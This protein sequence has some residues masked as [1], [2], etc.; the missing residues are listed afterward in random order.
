MKISKETF[1]RV[2]EF[3]QKFPHY[4]IGSNADLPIV[5]GSILSHDH[6]QSGNYAFAMDNAPIENRFKVK[7][8]E[9]IEA[10]I[11]KWPMSVI[12]LK[13]DDR[14]KVSELADYIFNKWKLY[15]DIE[16]EIAAFTDGV[17]HNTITPIARRTG[18]QY[19]LDLA[20][21]NNRTSSEHPDG[22]YH[23]HQNLH[24]I[25]KENIGLIEVMG[26]AVLPA[27]LK[28]ELEQ[29]SVYLVNPEKEDEMKHVE[30]LEKH[31]NWYFEIKE[32]Y[33]DISKENVMDILKREVGL[34][35]TDVLKDAGVFKRDKKG[36]EAFMKFLRTLSD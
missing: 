8:Y 33:K 24:H 16:V 25:K 11:I 28:D 27:R 1:D 12:R 19:E 15:S 30:E 36:K 7:G 22:I 29:L 35:F 9:D 20:L 26:L 10:G 34:K 23:P 14:S 13:G 32:K 21:R 31:L 4:C 2:L 18:T 3:V 5:G 6:F 17:P